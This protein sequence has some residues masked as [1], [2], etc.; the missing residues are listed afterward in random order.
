[1]FTS[2]VR[3]P[4][5][6]PILSAGKHRSP[7][8]GACFMELASLLAGESWTDHPSCTHPLL[9]AVARD[10]NDR[11]SDAARQQLAGLI[12]SVIGLTSNDLHVDARIALLC[13]TT[14]LPIVA[15]E[16]QRTMALAVLVCDRVLA[17]LDGRPAARLEEQNRLALAQ[18]PDAARWAERFPGGRLIAPQVFRRRS[19]PSIV[20][21]AIDAIAL[22]CVSA[23]DKILRDLLVG[24]I[25]QCAVWVRRDAASETRSDPEL[26]TASRLSDG[27]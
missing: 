17:D 6:M 5:L 27:T 18:A 9:A 12:P 8:K 23:P 1:M 11:T 25:D 19:A 21:A 7:R 13:A 22:A 15:A 4:T 10:V 24:A 20:S 3:M 26:V 16:R 2:D 14:A